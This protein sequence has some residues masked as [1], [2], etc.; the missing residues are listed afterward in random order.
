MARKMVGP[1]F[2]YLLPVCALLGALM[3]TGVFYLTQLGIPFITAGGT[4]VLTSLIGCIAFLIIAV[5]GRRSAGG[6]W[7]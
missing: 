5:R 7:L 3:V 1:D 6:E 2:R 4:G